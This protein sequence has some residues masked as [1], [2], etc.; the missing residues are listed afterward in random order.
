MPVKRLK[1]CIFL[2]IVFSPHLFNVVYS[3]VVFPVTGSTHSFNPRR[4]PPSNTP[5]ISRR[6]PLLRERYTR[7]PRTVHGKGRRLIPTTTDRMRSDDTSRKCRS[8]LVDS[9]FLLIVIVKYL[10]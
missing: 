7:I 9:F 4:R 10:F 8:Q 6:E 1:N 3:F 2:G 5:R